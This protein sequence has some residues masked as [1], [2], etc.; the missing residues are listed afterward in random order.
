MLKNKP[1]LLEK[2]SNL[3]TQDFVNQDMTMTVFM[4]LN[5]TDQYILKELRK[6]KRSSNL[7]YVVAVGVLYYIYTTI[8]E[9]LKTLEKY[10]EKADKE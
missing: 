5:K 9:R 2:H 1:D 6:V 10:E 4:E 3:L 7:R 8:N